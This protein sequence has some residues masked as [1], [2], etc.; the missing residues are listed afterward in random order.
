MIV[1]QNRDRYPMNPSP[2][3]SQ[4]AHG[5]FS[6][7]PSG[8][9][10]S[11]AVDRKEIFQPN[12]SYGV[13]LVHPTMGRLMRWVLDGRR[14]GVCQAGRWMWK[15]FGNVKGKFGQG[16][17]WALV[18]GQHQEKVADGRWLTSQAFFW[19]GGAFK[20]IFILPINVCSLG[21]C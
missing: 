11:A 6:T 17:R 21:K 20:Q 10:D 3:W 1:R 4:K 19:G 7:G 5:Q 8:P 18:R 15:V 14:Y 12:F 2:Q 9:L 16:C 13:F